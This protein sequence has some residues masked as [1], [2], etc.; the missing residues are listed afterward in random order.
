VAQRLG[1]VQHGH[2]VV[3][4][5]DRADLALVAKVGKAGQY[6][7]IG[8]PSVGGQCIWRRSMRS[9]PSLRSDAS[10]S[11]RMFSGEPT[12]AGGDMGSSGFH[13]SPALVNT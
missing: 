5:P 8:V 10:T 11:A 12:R 2:V 9:T 1:R 13:L 6:S 3:R 4:Q 7:S